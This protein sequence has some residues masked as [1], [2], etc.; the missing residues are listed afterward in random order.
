M[1]EMGTDSNYYPRVAA[2][3][4]NQN[5]HSVTLPPDNGHL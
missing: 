1:K 2:P 4:G 3:W 5:T